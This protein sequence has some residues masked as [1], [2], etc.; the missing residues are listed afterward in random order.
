MLPILTI[1]FNVEISL[2]NRENKGPDLC[3]YNVSL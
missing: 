2:I 3:V 1:L